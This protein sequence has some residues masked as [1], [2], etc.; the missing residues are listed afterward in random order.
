MTLKSGCEAWK[1]PL[2]GSQNK[3]TIWTVEPINGAFTCSGGANIEG[4]VGGRAPRLCREPLGGLPALGGDSLDRQSEQSLQHF[5]Q[6]RDSQESGWSG[7]RERGFSIK[8]NLPT[9]KDEKAKD[10]VTYCSWCFDVSVFCH[11]GWDDWHL[12]PYVFRSLQGFPG[13]LVR[14]LGEDATLGDVLWTLD[15]HC[16]DVMT[17]DT[18]RKEVYSLK[19]GMGENVAEFGVCL[20]QQIQIL[21]M[22]YHSRIQQEHVEGVEAGSLLWRP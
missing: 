7:Q 16:G 9:F 21:Q 5:N 8:V 12:L 14:S 3:L 17:F 19:Q 6:M 18:L 2:M 4:G 20:A 13:D 22:G 1:E 10:A 11:C 15:E